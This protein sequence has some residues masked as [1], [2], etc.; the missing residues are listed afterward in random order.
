MALFTDTNIISL[1]DLLQYETTL[2]QVAS[3]H[4]IDVNTKIGL[5]TSAIGNKLMLWLLNVGMSDPQWLNRRLLGLSTIVVTPPLERWLCLESLSYFFAEAYN[6]Q[7][8][9]RFQGKWTEYQQLAGAA[10]N[11]TLLSGIGIV[12]KPLPQPALPLVTIAAGTLPAQALFVQTAWVDEAG[13]E[14][15]PSPVNGE[16]LPANSAVTVAMAEGVSKTPQSA[17]GWNIYMSSISTGLTLQNTTPVAAGST[18]SL[19]TAGVNNN[20]GFIAAQ[21]LGQSPDFYIRISKQ[22]QR[23]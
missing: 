17:V 6:I 19:S 2:V 5:A 21:N 9:S 12:Y 11:S 18:W 4:G 15:A 22:I 16:V 14:S 3:S 1:N 8:N 7:L 23:G 20:S 10:A 13:N